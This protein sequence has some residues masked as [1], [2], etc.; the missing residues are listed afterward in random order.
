M[1]KVCHSI[2]V[3][4]EVTNPLIVSRAIGRSA[5]NFVCNQRAT[6][7]TLGNARGTS[8]LA[9]DVPV[10]EAPWNKGCS[11]RKRLVLH[12]LVSRLSS[13]MDAA[14]DSVAL[15][16]L[17]AGRGAV[18]LEERAPSPTILPTNPARSGDGFS[19]ESACILAENKVD[20]GGAGLG[21]IEALTATISKNRKSVLTAFI[22]DGMCA[23]ANNGYPPMIQKEKKTSDQEL[24]SLTNHPFFLFNYVFLYRGR[25]LSRELAKYDLDYPRWRVLSV[26]NEYPK[27]TMQVLADAVG[28]DRT[29]L[30]H[31][32]RLMVNAHLLSKA[33]RRSDRRSVSLSLTEQGSDKFKKVLPII[34]DYNEKCFADFSKEET[35]LFIQFLRRVIVNIQSG[36]ERTKENL[37]A[38]QD[39]IISSIIDAT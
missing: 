26:L 21:F 1:G 2:A 32:V 30:T 34:V 29:S 11:Y 13:R 37:D 20:N 9:I 28:V 38:V 18:L 39:N 24:F 10:Y 5:Q 23:Q 35:D 7:A 27:C 36:P 6:H 8:V 33:S 19:S 3:G 17:R 15:G 12:M 4:S 31:T 14:L 22:P 25:E 16:D